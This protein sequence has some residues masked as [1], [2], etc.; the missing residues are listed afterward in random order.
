MEDYN[1]EVG[2]RYKVTIV[3]F[4][5]ECGLFE[6]GQEFTCH[7]VDCDGYCW[8]EDVLYRTYIGDW[9]VGR[10]CVATN[11]DLLCGAVVEI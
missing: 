6:I 9:K 7:F 1:F 10:W 8:T 2:K 11:E 3:N 5:E 4:Y